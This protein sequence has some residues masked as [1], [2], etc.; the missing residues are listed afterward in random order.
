MAGPFDIYDCEKTGCIQVGANPKPAKQFAGFSGHTNRLCPKESAP[1]LK[2]MGIKVERE[3][4]VC[5]EDVTWLPLVS[6]CPTCGYKPLPVYEEKEYNEETTANQIITEYFEDIKKGPELQNQPPSVND[7]CMKTSKASEGFDSIIQD[8]RTLKQSIQKCKASGQ[9]GG[10]SKP[11]SSRPT[12]DPNLLTVFTELKNMY[13]SGESN[14]TKR[15]K[16]KEICDEACRLAKA[17]RRRAASKKPASHPCGVVYKKRKRAPRMKDFKSRLYVPME[18]MAHR[19][20]AHATCGNVLHKVPAHM[21]WLWTQCP[22][23]AR[24]GWR[25]G[26]IR[27]SIRELMSYFLRDYPVDTIPISKYM[28][29]HKQKPPISHEGEER[30]EE[31]V[32]VPTLHIEKR[33]N[34]YVITL[35][36]LKDAEGLKRAANPY[37]KMKPIQFRIVKNPLLK[38]VREMKRCLKNMGYSKCQCH[39]PVMECYCRSFIDKKL[40]VDDVRRQCALRKMPCCERELVLSDTTDSEAEFDFG[41]TPPA[42]LMKPERLKITHMTH[43]ETQYNENDWAMPTMFPHPPNAY[44]QY[45][46]CVTGER[47]NRFNWIFGKGNVHEV[48]KPP[49]MKNKGKE[50]PVR[51]FHGAPLPPEVKRPFPDP[52]PVPKRTK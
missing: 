47:K 43:T 32:Q 12:K 6:A 51:K 27:R 52:K 22:L 28:S 9:G 36:P 46:G 42:G 37:V 19:S 26:A 16:I 39:R 3:C 31:L 17:T 13:Q 50:K 29:Y 2:E 30:P 1:K 15:N 14:E 20:S 35:R 49:K 25:P 44:V 18:P 33:N 34:E 5:K 4:P 48:P 21:G 45:G 11:A 7:P 24:P 40:L 38:E 8:Y 23:A 41:V 10:I